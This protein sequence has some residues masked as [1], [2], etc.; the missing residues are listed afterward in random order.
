MKAVV[1]NA[2]YTVQKNKPIIHLFGWTERKKR[3][4]LVI[5]NFKPYCYIE[6]DVYKKIKELYPTQLVIE[7]KESEVRSFPDNREL[8]IL[9]F[10]IPQDVARFRKKMDRLNVNTYEA[11]IPF[12]KRF[13][14]DNN[15]KHGIDIQ[16]ASKADKDNRF[17]TIIKPT[18]MESI[19][20]YLIFDIEVKSGKESVKELLSK[21]NRPILVIAYW[22]N[23]SKEYNVLSLREYG[24][25][26]K[27]I[28]EFL[29]RLKKIDPDILTN[30]NIEKFDLIYLIE[31]CKKLR[32]PY[33]KYLSPIGK[34]SLDKEKG[35]WRIIGRSVL[36]YA[37]LYR[38]WIGRELRTSWYEALDTIA[39][40]HLDIKKIALDG[41][42][43]EVWKKDPELIENRAKR[44]VEIIVKLEEELKLID[45][46]EEIRKNVGCLLSDVFYKSRVADI[47][48]LRKMYGKGVL[49]NRPK[50]RERG[51]EDTYIGAWIIEPKIGIYKNIAVFDFAG[52][53]PRLVL[54]YNISPETLDDTGELMIN[55]ELRFLSSQKGILPEI[56]SNILKLKKKIK[57]E[58][59]NLPSNIPYSKKQALLTRHEAIKR[60]LNSFYGVTPFHSRLAR[61]EIGAAISMAGRKHLKEL[62][63]EA[64]RN[65]YQVLYSDTDSVFI[66]IPENLTVEELEYKIKQ[67]VPR[68]LELELKYVFDTLI[69]LS[70]KRYVAITSNGDVIRKGIQAI[71][72]DIEEF[73]SEAQEYII[74]N[75]L[76]NKERSNIYT[77]LTN[78]IKDIEF[79]RIP[80]NKLGR[81][82]RIKKKINEYKV[83]SAH[84]KA[85][86]FSNKYLNTSFGQDSKPLILRVSKV[87]IGLPKTQWIAI[88]NDI[89]KLKKGF[90]IDKKY[91]INRLRSVLKSFLILLNLDWRKL[92]RAS[93]KSIEEYLQH[94]S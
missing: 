26:R 88:S 61:K 11:D 46:L 39:S 83:E 23:W 69:L 18:E 1:N 15:I 33:T 34:V 57:R 43:E 80:I 22:D 42:Y 81:P 72:S 86:E 44:D 12:A 71:R 49:P 82:I 24:S 9:Y 78:V 17:K 59:S 62:I 56:V 41:T 73:C 29:T 19:L 45:L 94:A 47:S 32:I 65:G 40:R 75:I 38:E 4:H 14:V 51:E 68:D 30:Y 6:K 21:T 16:I 28:K 10:R 54:K 48:W 27:L 2:T 64:T 76:S 5:E 31:R 63:S 3:L 92:N 74:E 93:S 36:D 25:E 84:L 20:K 77:Y 87:P 53:Y 58:I 60:I 85:I 89:I 90:V 13:L 91:Y 79:D 52:F 35:I 66:R 70:K 55:E 37:E 7:E 8:L 67:L 50:Y